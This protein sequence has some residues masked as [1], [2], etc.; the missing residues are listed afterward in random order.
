M[1]PLSISTGIAGLLTLIVSIG[2]VGFEYV[3]CVRDAPKA[4]KTLVREVTCLEEVLRSIRNELLLDSELVR[5]SA[6]RREDRWSG[7]DA[8]LRECQ[9]DL[10]ALLREL[11]EKG[12]GGKV[13]ILDRALWY[14][15]EGEMKERIH[16]IC[17]YRD[18]FTAL[19]SQDI[20][21]VSTLTL[22]EVKDWRQEESN[23]KILRWLSP[24]DFAARHQDISSKRQ[25]ETLKWLLSSA[26]YLTWSRTDVPLINDNR[27]IWCYGDPGAGKTYASSRV[28]DHWL[29][30]PEIHKPGIAYVYCNYDDQNNRT[31]SNILGCILKQL[32]VQCQMLPDFMA[33]LYMK[34]RHTL[35][36]FEREIFWKLL[37]QLNDNFSRILIVVDALDELENDGARTRRNLMRTMSM[38]RES[39]SDIR[40]F[41]TSRPHLEDINNALDRFPKLRIE[42]RDNDIRSFLLQRIN[43]SGDLED[44][45]Q[46]DKDFQRAIIETLVRKANK[47]LVKHQP[48]YRPNIC[49]FLIPALH[50]D[51][52][53]E[54]TSRAEIEEIL[55]NITGTIGDAY[56]STLYRIKSLPKTRSDLALNTLMW[57][58][59]S[60]RPLQ[61]PELQEALAV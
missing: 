51:R 11:R 36:S 57:L 8:L 20:S 2:Q 54:S 26:E 29:E 9:K 40:I 32:I 19:T 15:N 30:T 39:R 17:R 55:E 49:K 24:L 53:L 52:L 41:A 27:V 42:A 60:K 61:F 45:V 12:Q 4:I 6:Q 50:I 47:M 14:F 1:D 3:S 5:L 21:A 46:D 59:H 10:D 25:R 23:Q 13:K 58:S 34:E 38:S 48:I 37:E 44:V 28:L 33:R 35:T 43:G 31:L 16:M 7:R 18:Q 22:K 56:A